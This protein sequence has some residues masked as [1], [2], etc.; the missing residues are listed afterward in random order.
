MSIFQLIIHPQSNSEYAQDFCKEFSDPSNSR[1]VYGCNDWAVSVANNFQVNGYVD[2]F[3]EA[4]EFHG[5]P[6]IRSIDVPKGSLVVSAI[7]GVK[8]LTALKTLCSLKIKALDYYAF[9]RYSGLSLKNV[10]Y[11][12]Q[13]KGEFEKN[14]SKYE[15]LY[16]ELFDEESRLVFE[17]LI[18][19][20]LSYDINFLDKFT[21]AQ[22]RQYFEPFLELKDGEIFVDVGSYDGY[23]SLEFIKRC[24]GYS[25]IDIFEPEP[26][27]MI[28][29]RR[30][31]GSYNNIYY[32]PFGVSSE[33]KAVQFISNGSA[34]SLSDMGNVTIDLRRIDDMLQDG[35][36]FL[37]MDIEGGE[38]DAL[39][40]AAATIAKFN[41]KI[42]ISVYH[43]VDDLWKIPT[44]ILSYN[45]NY[46]IFLRH[47]TEGLA[48]TVMFF[49]PK[50][51]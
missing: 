22:D 1:Y 11:M 48:E 4:A 41:P 51:V 31:L 39:R 44:T 33:D 46:N 34:S 20:R 49:I 32:H 40:G 10:F 38:L 43:K 6:V 19:F 24:P 14:R 15:W 42:A 12:E 30:S 26:S 18:N 25:K 50:M 2:D 27:N 8:P 13:F 35:Y 5:K 29:V 21:D 9:Q 36:S 23:T 47:Y 45:K 28:N 37:K 7:V 3:I 17:R 16:Q